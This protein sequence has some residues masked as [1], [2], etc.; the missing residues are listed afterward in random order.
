MGGLAEVLV[1][2]RSFRYNHVV[3]YNREVEAMEAHGAHHE[4]DC[5]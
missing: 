1:I 4:P 2:T 5:L 3:L